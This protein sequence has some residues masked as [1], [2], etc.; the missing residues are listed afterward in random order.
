MS[1]MENY[2]NTFRMEAE[3]LLADIEECVLIIE[4]NPQDMDTLNRLFRAMHTI[5]GSGGMFGFTAVAEFTHH[6][7]TVLDR[8]R[9][10][11][12]PVTKELIDLI[13][14]S[15]DQISRLMSVSGA[16]TPADHARSDGII[17]GFE[18]SFWIHCK[19]QPKQRAQLLL[20][21]KWVE[22]SNRSSDS[23][24]RINFVPQP[25]IFASG[26]GPCVAPG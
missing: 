17:S 15:R 6:V 1:D 8:V 5:K 7:E 13:L 11:S 14:A 22:E 12:I 2:E 18:W 25:S 24:Y 23:T 3:E 4:D 20:P 19:T 10:G 16:V 9:D 21:K 26:T